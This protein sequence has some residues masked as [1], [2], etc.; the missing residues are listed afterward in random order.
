MGGDGGGEGG[1]L[2]CVYVLKALGKPDWVGACW[3]SAGEEKR[4]RRWDE[5]VW[6][7]SK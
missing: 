3:R 2:R 4:L 5:G 6:S 7:L 1:L